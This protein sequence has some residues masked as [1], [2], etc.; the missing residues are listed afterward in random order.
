MK[1]YEV[2]KFIQPTRPSS[3]ASHHRALGLDHTYRKQ[4]G[5]FLPVTVVNLLKTP[6]INP[7]TSLFCLPRKTILD[8]EQNIVMAV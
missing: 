3:E 6:E 2:L 8:K 1:R 4:K 7:P 5:F